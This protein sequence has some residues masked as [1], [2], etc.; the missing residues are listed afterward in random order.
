MTGRMSSE[1]T[2]QWPFRCGCC[3]ELYPEGTVAVYAA[4]GSKIAVECPNLTDEVLTPYPTPRSN[5]YTPTDQEMAE[6]RTKMCGRCFLVHA[7]ECM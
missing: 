1:W 5:D 2:A 3:N 4:D 7:G 6:A